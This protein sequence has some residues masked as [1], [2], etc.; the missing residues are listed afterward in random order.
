M[1]LEKWCSVLKDGDGVN[2]SP[3]EQHDAQEFLLQVGMIFLVCGES[4]EIDLF[5]LGVRSIG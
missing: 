4:C 1:V 3:R 2:V 5:Y